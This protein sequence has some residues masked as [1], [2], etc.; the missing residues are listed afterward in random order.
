M[1]YSENVLF[2]AVNKLNKPQPQITYVANCILLIP[3]S[4]I[5]NYHTYI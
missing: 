1:N 4:H 2:F 3:D 5:C